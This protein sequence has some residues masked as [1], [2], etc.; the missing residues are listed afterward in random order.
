[1]EVHIY[2]YDVTTHAVKAKGVFLLRCA[3][4]ERKSNPE[5]LSQQRKL[6]VKGTVVIVLVCGASGSTVRWSGLQQNDLAAV[7][8]QPGLYLNKRRSQPQQ[9]TRLFV[10]DEHT[11]LNR[12]AV[13][14]LLVPAA[15]RQAVDRHH[16]GI[17][18]GVWLQR[19]LVLCVKR[20]CLLS[21][22]CSFG[23]FI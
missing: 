4:Y 14:R 23:P 17:V 5:A 16:K 13:S 20:L 6:D 1:M 18:Q 11:S 2:L 21:R 10:P 9:T 7:R 15:T 3:S 8:P 22:N 12:C 19:L